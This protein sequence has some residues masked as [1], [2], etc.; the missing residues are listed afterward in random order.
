VH[1]D[2]AVR[3]ALGASAAP[4]AVVGHDADF[5][6]GS[7]NDAIDAAQEAD[8]VVAMPASGWEE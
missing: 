1:L 2:V 3:A 8:R 6:A 7:A 4:D 5:A